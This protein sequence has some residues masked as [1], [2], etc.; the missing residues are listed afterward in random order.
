MGRLRERLPSGNRGELQLLGPRGGVVTMFDRTR[1]SGSEPPVLS[2][3]RKKLVLRYMTDPLEVE[4]E[5][6]PAAE[7]LESAPPEPAQLEPTLRAVDEPLP[8][9]PAPAARPS[10]NGNALRPLP[11]EPAKAEPAKAKAEQPPKRGRPPGRKARRQVHFHVDPEEDRLLLAAAGRF[12]SQQKGLVAA[13]SA[14]EEVDALREQVKLLEAECARQRQLLVEAQA[15]FNK[16][17][18]SS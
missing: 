14:L 18:R 4:V 6:V 1:R 15:V 13:L 7:T 5:D 8:A 16:S 11:S 3:E 12:G 2:D 17:R 10:E 9:E